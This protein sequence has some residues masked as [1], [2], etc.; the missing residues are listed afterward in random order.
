VLVTDVV[1]SKRIEGVM[2]SNI[3]A[4]DVLVIDVDIYGDAEVYLVLDLT[5]QIAPP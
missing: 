5:V 2:S 1:I 4:T 3:A